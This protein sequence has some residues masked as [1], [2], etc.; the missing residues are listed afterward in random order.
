MSRQVLQMKYHP[1]KKEVTFS[2]SIS[3]KEVEITGSSGSVLSKYINKRGQFV[4]QDHGNQFFEDI[5]EAFDGEDVI[6]L[7]VTTTR[8]D[9]EDFKQMIEYFNQ[10]SD[11]KISANL[12]AELPDMNAAYEAIKNHGLKSIDILKINRDKFHEVDSDNP[13]VQLCIENF[14]KEINEAAN[15]IHNKINTLEQNSVNVC[16]SGPYSSGKSLLIDSLIGYAILPTDIRP[17]TAAMFMISSPKNG[18]NVRINFHIDDSEESFSEI[19]WNEQEGNFVFVAGPSESKTRRSIQEVM[20]GCKE[21]KQHEQVHEIL[22]A[23]NSNENV[24]RVINVYFPIAIDNDKVQFTIYDT[25][26][27]D[28]GVLAHKNILKDALS[29]QTHSILVFVT[30]PNGLSGGGNKAL[31]EYCQKS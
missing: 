16:F 26:G 17:E 3:G 18:K 27:T 31:L 21:K 5:L 23:L 9:F 11:I 8:K 15:G 25:P 28:S 30:Y 13:N 19:A 2:R 6:S 10:T 14:S 22:N 12:L 7:D 4:L 29:E 20:N 1:A 24:E